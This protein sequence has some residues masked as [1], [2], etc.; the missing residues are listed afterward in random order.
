M[1]ACNNTTT[2]R[3][4]LVNRM[5]EYYTGIQVRLMEKQEGEQHQTKSTPQHN[6]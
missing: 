6:W 3:V 4:W 5:Q 1:Y 2:I